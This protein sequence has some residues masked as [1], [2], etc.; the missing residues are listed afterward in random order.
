MARRLTASTALPRSGRADTAR[1]RR[2]SSRNTASWAVPSRA[3]AVAG[4]LSA[5]YMSGDQSPAAAPA[6]ARPSATAPSAASAPRRSASSRPDASQKPSCC[7][8][9]QTKSRFAKPMA[10]I[11]VAARSTSTVS[12][13]VA[14][15]ATEATGRRSWAAARSGTAAVHST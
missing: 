9:S 10:A 12:A 5:A 11:P 13:N 15:T 1:S 2:R 8:S 4:G 3:S 7:T 6:T 14:S